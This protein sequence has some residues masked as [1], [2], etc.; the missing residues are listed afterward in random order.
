V[1][2]N[3]FHFFFSVITPTTLLLRRYFQFCIL[4]RYRQ[5]VDVMRDDT[6]FASMGLVSKNGKVRLDVIRFYRVW[7]LFML[8]QNLPV[9]LVTDENLNDTYH[10]GSWCT[11][12]VEALKHCN[13]LSKQLMIEGYQ[14]MAAVES[15]STN[16]STNTTMEMEERVGLSPAIDL[17]LIGLP[18][19]TMYGG[20]AF[21]AVGKYNIQKAEWSGK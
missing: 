2:T 7:S 18:T 6:L 16:S 9:L 5:L 15:L 20:H 10:E 11:W 13:A 3:F 4:N 14:Q 8:F 1:Y 12:H 19:A 21:S 17:L